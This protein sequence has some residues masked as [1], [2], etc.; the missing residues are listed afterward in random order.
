M[1][2]VN[3]VVQGSNDPVW[4]QTPIHDKQEL[5]DNLIEKFKAFPGVIFNFTQ[6][7]EDAVDEALTGLKSAGRKS[8][9]P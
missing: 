7:A 9:W 5:T 4:R 2:A 3:V 8:I 1:H 6:P